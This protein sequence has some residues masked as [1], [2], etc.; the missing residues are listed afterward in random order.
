MDRILPVI[1]YTETRQGHRREI[2]F[3]VYLK[4]AGFSVPVDP[5]HRHYATLEAYHR[6]GQLEWVVEVGHW[7]YG[8]G[9]H[10]LVLPREQWYVYKDRAR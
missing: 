1:K 2:I 9:V 8:R 6:Q 3:H 4:D 7:A 5:T 10:E